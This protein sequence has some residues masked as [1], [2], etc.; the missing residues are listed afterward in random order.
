MKRF[1]LLVFDWDGTL[2]D[3]IDRIVNSLQH[4][5]RTA[6]GADISD[7]HA[8]SV[9]GLG[10]AEAV[11][12]LHPELDQDEHKVELERIADAY[13]QHYLYENDIEAPLFDGVEDMLETLR[14]E[15]YTLAIA[16]GKSRIGLDHTMQEHGV[17]AIFSI[18][19]T[20]TET[21][22]K[23]HPLMLE[24]IMKHTGFGPEH[25]LMIGDS[26]HDLKMAVNA[27]VAGIAVTHGVHDRRTLERL[28]PLACFDHVTELHPYLGDTKSNA[29]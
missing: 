8:K 15:G 24:E 28:S 26:E 29:G 6:I 20:P 4:A 27:T 21:R 1:P 14:S 23:P 25:T 19:R 3:S 18:T 13:R 16:T 9:I 22:S 17:E 7:S 5:S 12:S 11:A 10:L 2:V